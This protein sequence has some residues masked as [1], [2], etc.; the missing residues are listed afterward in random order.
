MLLSP[1]PPGNRLRARAARTATALAAYLDA[2][3]GGTAT[4]AHREAVLAARHELKT[5]FAAGPIRPTGLATIDQGLAN[6]VELLE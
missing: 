2:A 4:T 1:K 5:A 3:V 6:V